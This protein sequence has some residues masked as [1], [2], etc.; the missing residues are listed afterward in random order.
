VSLSARS[1]K[2]SSSVGVGISGELRTDAL[3]S[4][5]VDVD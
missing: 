2:L 3:E 5:C 1:V 4:G